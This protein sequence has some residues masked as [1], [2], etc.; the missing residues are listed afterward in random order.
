MATRR[1]TAKRSTGARGKRT[2]GA[3]KTTSRPRSRAAR[4]TAGTSRMKTAR[5]GTAS[6]RT[7][8]SRGRATSSAAS[9]RPTNGFGS[10]FRMA[11]QP[12][13]KDELKKLMTGQRPTGIKG[14]RSVHLFD[15]G[16]DEVW[17]VAVFTN[18]K[19]YRDNANSAEQNQRYMEMRRLLQQ[20]PEWHDANVQSFNP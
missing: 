19:S 13:R 18:E 3:R 8:A 12:G 20:D 15:T 14:M 9:S 1:T 11:V 2:T 17:G 7:T 5:R 6:R 4:K 10:I 16:G